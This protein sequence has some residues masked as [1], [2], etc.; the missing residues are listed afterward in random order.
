MSQTT[1]TNRIAPR[2]APD[3]LAGFLD[4]VLGPPMHAPVAWGSALVPAVSVQEFDKE[5]V[6]AVE[7]PGVGEESIEV[8]VENNVLTISGEKREEH[9]AES[10]GTR[11]LQERAFGDFRRTFRLPSTVRADAISAEL[12]NGLLTLRLPKAEEARARKIEVRRPV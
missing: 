8:A 7:L 6:L 1:C 9:E 3:A 11:H 4:Q 12:E 10:A 2:S 5:L